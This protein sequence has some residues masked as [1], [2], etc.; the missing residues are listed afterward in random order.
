M[1]PDAGPDPVYENG[2]GARERRREREED[3]ASD[4][5]LSFNAPAV[6]N[7]VFFF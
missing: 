7:I 6:S 3:A 5:G 4:G 2:D 1:L